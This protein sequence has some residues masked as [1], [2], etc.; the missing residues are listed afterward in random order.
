MKTYLI[1]T[2]LIITSS[3]SSFAQEETNNKI[4]VQL[5]GT[6][7][8]YNSMYTS[9]TLTQYGGIQ[10]QELT[11]SNMGYV[12][13]TQVAYITNNWLFQSGLL[14]SSITENFEFNDTSDNITTH[15]NKNNQYR[16]LNVPINVG[17]IINSTHFSFEIKSGIT[18]G[19]NIYKEGLTY[20]F[21]IKKIIP[22]DANFTTLELQYSISTVIKYRLSNT[23]NIIAE[24]FYTSG[25]NS[26]W[27][28]TPFFAWKRIRYGC[29]LGIEFLFNQK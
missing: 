14:Y 29:Y 8:F 23:I 7:L 17:Y 20:D 19:I 3:L 22:L 25:I 11:K 5:L 28:E 10:P 21:A 15:I 9:T 4:S 18:F 1:L 26:L 2:I 12:L 13:G 24:P 16:Y 6:P 27:D